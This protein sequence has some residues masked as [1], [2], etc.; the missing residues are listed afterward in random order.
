MC[1]VVYF[2]FCAAAEA[3]FAVFLD[4]TGNDGQLLL[5]DLTTVSFVVSDGIKVPT[6]CICQ[7]LSIFPYQRLGAVW[8]KHDRL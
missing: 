1:G 2:A 6:R 8:Q 5:Y 7:Q 4:S 3:V